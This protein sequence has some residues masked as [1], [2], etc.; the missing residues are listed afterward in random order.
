MG[1]WEAFASKDLTL[2]QQEMVRGAANAFAITVTLGGAAMLGG[3]Q[4]IQQLGQALNNPKIFG[5]GM[6]VQ[7]ATQWLMGASKAVDA[8]ARGHGGRS[9]AKM[10]KVGPNSS[11]SFWGADGEEIE[12]SFGRSIEMNTAGPPKEFVGPGG[13]VY[14]YLLAPNN[15]E[16]GPLLEY[17]PNPVG[18]AIEAKGQLLTLKQIL[19][20]YPEGVNLRWAAC[21][22][23]PK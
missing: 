7:A 2:D 3:G 5:A 16:Y 18:Q 11:V 13:Q 4:S 9:D 19:G 8:V 14:N 1:F 21:R 17:S 15:E 23:C 22:S 6:D 10:I 20:R 12:D